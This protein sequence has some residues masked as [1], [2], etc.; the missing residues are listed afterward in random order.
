MLLLNA[1]IHSLKQ[2]FSIA[3]RWLDAANAGLSLTFGS[4]HQFYKK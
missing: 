4:L 2:L 1:E 3:V